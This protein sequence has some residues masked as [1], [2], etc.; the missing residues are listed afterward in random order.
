MTMQLKTLQNRSMYYWLVGVLTSYSV[1]VEDAF[2]DEDLELPTVSVEGATTV[3]TPAEMGNP[4]RERVRYWNIDIFAVNKDQQDALEQIILD[5]LDLGIIVY[6]YNE[7]F[8]PSSPSIIGSLS[9]I[10]EVVASPVRVF[11]DLVEKLYWRTR[12][13]FATE[14]NTV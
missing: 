13:T 9:P 3:G 11:P 6:D 7:G 4:V 12:L 8:P 2:P 5:A 1:N 10:G 14:Y